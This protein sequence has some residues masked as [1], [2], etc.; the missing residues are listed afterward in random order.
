MEQTNTK[1]QITID[2]GDPPLIDRG[3]QVSPSQSVPDSSSPKRTRASSETS[4]W[5]RTTKFRKTYFPDVTAEMWNDWHWQVS[6]RITTLSQISRFLT[7]TPEEQQA[8]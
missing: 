1:Q 8:L 5:G 6:H 4:R 2:D 3:M 7:L